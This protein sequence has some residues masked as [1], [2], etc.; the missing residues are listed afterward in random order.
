MIA[1]EAVAVAM[2]VV[3]ATAAAAIVTLAAAAASHGDPAIAVG[4]QGTEQARLA[5]VVSPAKAEASSSQLLARATA[6][7]TRQ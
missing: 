6:S 5:K 1:G 7:G 3:A 4:R 2:A